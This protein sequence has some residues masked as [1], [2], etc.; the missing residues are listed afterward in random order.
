[1]LGSPR[2]LLEI[3]GVTKD[4]SLVGFQNPKMLSDNLDFRRGVR[5][6]NVGLDVFVK[7]G[8]STLKGVQSLVVAVLS[9]ENFATKLAKLRCNKRQE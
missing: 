6:V 5:C 9:F 3:L 2:P 8:N 1:M 7:F 4:K